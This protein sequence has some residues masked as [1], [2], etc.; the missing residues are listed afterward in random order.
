MLCLIY[1]FIFFGKLKIPPA[2][3]RMSTL[4]WFMEEA[5]FCQRS[6]GFA[7]DHNCFTKEA[8]IFLF[9]FQLEYG[10]LKLSV[11]AYT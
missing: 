3:L 5:E 1:L 2:T 7:T 9:L 6:E 11:N 8:K 4:V 10:P